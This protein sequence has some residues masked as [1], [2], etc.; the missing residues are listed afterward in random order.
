M[1][2]WSSAMS[3]LNLTIDFWFT[4]THLVRAC[5]YSVSKYSGPGIKLNFTVP[6]ILL[7]QKL[8]MEVVQM[9]VMFSITTVG[10]PSLVPAF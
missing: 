1:S 8:R 10:N 9:L 3:S 5:S 7:L 4:V 6:N 2:M